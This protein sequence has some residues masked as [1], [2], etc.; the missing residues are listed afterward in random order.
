MDFG[1]KKNL[2]NVRII[3]ENYRRIIKNMDNVRIFEFVL[4]T[5]EKYCFFF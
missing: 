1:F 5:G 2:K 3:F 4:E